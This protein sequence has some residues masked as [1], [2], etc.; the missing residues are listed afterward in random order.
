MCFSLS[1]GQ[2]DWGVGM[3][4]NDFAAEDYCYRVFFSPE[5]EEYVGKVAEFPSLSVLEP[6]QIDAL[7]GI[8]GAVRFTLAEMKESGE[9]IPEPISLRNY[10]GHIS[11]RMTPEQHRFVAMQAAEQ[12]VSINR[13][14]NSC[15]AGC[16]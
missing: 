13:Y 9:A 1:I 15:L 10:S 3:A 8:V 5:D 12:N 7:K 6:T 16:A 4:R 2:R 11:L 14:I